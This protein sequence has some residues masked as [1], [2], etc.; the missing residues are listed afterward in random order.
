MT[1]RNGIAG[2]GAGRILRRRIVWGI[3][4]TSIW[5]PFI[6]CCGECLGCSEDHQGGEEYEGLHVGTSD[7]YN[8]WVIGKMLNYVERRERC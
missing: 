6:S 5:R 7:R 8:D 3:I 4:A 1:G 2:I